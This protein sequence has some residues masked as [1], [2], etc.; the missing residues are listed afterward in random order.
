MR[1]GPIT[2]STPTILRRSSWKGATISEEPDSENSLFSEPMKMRTPSAFSDSPEQ[3]HEVALALEIVEQVADAL[4]VLLR[5]EV[6]QEV[7]LAAHDE[8]LAVVERARPFGEPGLD[9]LLRQLVEL[10]AGALQL[11]LDA[12]C[13][14]PPW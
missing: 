6:L 5:G 11:L 4:Q 13:A 12:R 10:G 7:G 2:P 3:L 9:D 8:A 14:P 1:V